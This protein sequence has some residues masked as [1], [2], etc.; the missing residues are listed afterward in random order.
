MYTLHVR[1]CEA[2]EL[3]MYIQCIKRTPSLY[4]QM[5]QRQLPSVTMCS[6]GQNLSRDF[7]CCVCLDSVLIDSHHFSCRSS[8]DGQSKTNLLL[9]C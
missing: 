4:Y 8:T 3:L 9:L 7:F 5:I 6:A 1:L 2:R